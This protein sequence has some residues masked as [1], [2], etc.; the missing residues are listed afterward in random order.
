MSAMLSCGGRRL[1]GGGGCAAAAGGGRRFAG[2]GGCAAA[3][4]AARHRYCEDAGRSRDG[5]APPFPPASP[6]AVSIRSRLSRSGERLR[7]LLLSSRRPF[8]PLRLRFLPLLLLCL[9][10][11]LASELLAG[12][13]LMM[14][15]SCPLSGTYLRTRSRWLERL[16]CSL[17]SSY[18][19]LPV[20]HGFQFP[21]PP[22][23]AGFVHL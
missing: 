22:A 13:G 1:A 10:L 16:L 19:V 12:G 14:L 3:A 7:F 2:D 21:G 20:S 15:P 8:E 23:A 4:E 9:S 5:V 6:L 11:R 18:L 17:Y